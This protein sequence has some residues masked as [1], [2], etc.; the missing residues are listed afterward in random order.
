MTL[1]SADSALPLAAL[2]GAL[3]AIGAWLFRLASRALARRRRVARLTRAYAGQR[4]AIPLVESLGYTVLAEQPRIT[5]TVHVDG[6]PFVLDLRPDLFLERGGERYVAD[7]KTGRAAPDPLF[8]A[9]RRQLLEYATAIGASGA[10]LVDVERAEVRA[11]SFPRP[12]T[13]A[14]TSIR[15]AALGFVA[16]AAACAA[17]LLR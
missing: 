11:V 9:T 15:W 7:V 5:M 3:L 13:R 4:N 6:A 2:A 16:G 1:S 14:S 12:A 8:A 17:F 10:L